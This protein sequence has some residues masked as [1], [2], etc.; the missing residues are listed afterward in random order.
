[1]LAVY[2]LFSCLT[3][4]RGIWKTSPGKE[5]HFKLERKVKLKKSRHLPHNFTASLQDEV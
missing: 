1:M 5:I 3:E 2:I 4:R